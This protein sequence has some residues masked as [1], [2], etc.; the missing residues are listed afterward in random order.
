MAAMHSANAP[1]GRNSSI[2][3]D[4][5]TNAP[6]DD[7]KK[8]VPA[9]PP[10]QTAAPVWRMQLIGATDILMF[11]IAS[12]KGSGAATS[13]VSA[14]AQ[15]LPNCQN[16]NARMHVRK[17]VRCIGASLGATFMSD[18]DHGVAVL[19]KLGIRRQQPK[20]LGKRLCNENPIERIAVPAW[21]RVECGGMCW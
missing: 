7:T 17:R 15:T 4:G 16:A 8:A 2:T 12:M 20:R 14:R 6:R 3:C 13:R 11:A 21:Q 10:N 18:Q 1:P 9:F 5:V 19:R